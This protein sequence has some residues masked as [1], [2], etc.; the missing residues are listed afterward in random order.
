VGRQQAASG[1]GKLPARGVGHAGTAPESPQPSP[2]MQPTEPSRPT[3]NNHCL[4][5]A[6]PDVLRPCDESHHKPAAGCRQVKRRCMR[7][8]NR[9]LQ[10]AVQTA[11]RGG[12]SGISPLTLMQALPR[13]YT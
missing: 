11:G 12:S 1:P 5:S 6:C 2:L 13:P 9:R 3:Y 7:G 10:G 4:V 8:A